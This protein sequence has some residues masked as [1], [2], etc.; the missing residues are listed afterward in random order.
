MET[1]PALAPL[2][3]VSLSGQTPQPQPQSAELQRETDEEFIAR[4]KPH[5]AD[6]EKIREVKYS[7][8][9]RR[10][11]LGVVFFLLLLPF[12][13]FIDY[14]LMFTRIV[15]SHDSNRMAGLTFAMAGSLWY[16]A[17]APKRQYV[18]AYKEEIMPRIVKALGLS[19]YEEKGMIPIEQL[20]PSKI[21]PAYDKYSSEDYFA[22]KYKGTPVRFAQIKLEHEKGS[23]KDR[24]EVT[25]F[26]GLALLVAMPRGQ[27]SGKTLMVPHQISVS[28]WVEEKMLGMEKADLVDPAFEKQYT[29]FTTDQVE[30]RYLLDP[31]MVEKVQ[32]LVEIYSATDAR[33]SYYDD[34]VLVLLSCKRNLFEP[35]DIAIPSTDIASLLALKKEVEKTLDLIDCVDTFLARAHSG[36]RAQG[37]AQ[38]PSAQ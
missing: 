17:T 10:C 3:P 30:A 5:L 31:A 20:K 16:W 7:V 19:A 11:K 9:K 22:G 38:T 28:E 6:I 26:S 12:T 23:G 8:Y 27:F 33:V 37:A 1:N 35:P 13:G 21:L 25:V 36:D 18:H 34:R 15:F 2:M 14:I 4:A 29:V 32:K 24:H